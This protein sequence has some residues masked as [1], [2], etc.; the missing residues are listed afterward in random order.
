MCSVVPFPLSSFPFFFSSLSLLASS[1]SLA[2]LQLQDAL[3]LLGA[4]YGP[5][6]RHDRQLY[7]AIDGDVLREA[8]ESGCCVRKD[9]SGCVQV[10]SEESCPVSHT[11]YCCML[12]LSSSFLAL[13]PLSHCL[14]ISCIFCVGIIVHLSSISHKH[15]T[16][17]Q[18][19]F[20]RF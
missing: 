2:S 8:S 20:A 9:Q 13:L 12:Q 7:A 14:S 10:L 4:K 17:G 19:L 15:S 5:C 18:V 11:L 3:V 6:M 16:K 1:I